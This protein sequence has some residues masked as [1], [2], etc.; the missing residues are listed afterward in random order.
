M[1]C[2]LAVQA[3]SRQAIYICAIEIRLQQRFSCTAIAS[4]G[5]AAHIPYLDAPDEGEP[6]VLVGMEVSHTVD[7]PVELA[8]RL[9]MLAGDIANSILRTATVLLGV[10]L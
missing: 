7:E 2:R 3:N 5:N 10:L 8:F 6:L 1:H 4:A 9:S